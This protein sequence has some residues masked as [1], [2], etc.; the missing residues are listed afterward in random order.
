MPFNI[1]YEPKV[2]TIREMF[3]KMALAD[4][5]E[6]EALKAKARKY[7]EEERE[8]RREKAERKNQGGQQLSL[9]HI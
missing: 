7:Q 2:S 5:R 3:E 8:S 1:L 4:H 9:I 6:L